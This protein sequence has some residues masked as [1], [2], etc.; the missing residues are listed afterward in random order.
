MKPRRF[1]TDAERDVVRRRY[2]HERT[3][4]IARDLNRSPGAIFGEASSMGLRK[5]PE[6]MRDIHGEHLKNAGVG[7]RFQPNHAT[8][9]K[10]KAGCTGNHPNTKR[11]Q[12]KAGRLP[13][14]A[15]NYQPIG[16]LRINCDGCLQRKITDD[17]EIYP[18]QRWRSVHRIVWEEVNGPMP[19]GHI[20]VFRPGMETTD[21]ELIT[22]DRVELIT[23]A[24]LM[25]RNT[26]HNLPEEI[27]ELIILKTRIT[28]AITRRFKHEAQH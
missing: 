21:P 11:T 6:F 4:D 16:S 19:R 14:E 15:R 5:T 8:W 7:C 12:F 28:R 9:N 2:P 25:R 18:S 20:V 27:K 1:W 3:A 23:R 13:Q 17:P 26:R 24:E 22:I 10:G